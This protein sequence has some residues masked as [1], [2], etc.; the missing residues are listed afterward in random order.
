ML[1]QRKGDAETVKMT[2]RW[3]GEHDV[4]PLAYIKQIPGMTGA[5][6][7]VYDTPVGE[8]WQPDEIGRAHV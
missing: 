7:A 3:Y 5:V 4:I 6:T 2:F 8:V 1:P